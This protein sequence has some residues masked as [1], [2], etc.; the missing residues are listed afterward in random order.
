MT[1]ENILNECDK[2]EKSLLITHFSNN[3]ISSLVTM[4]HGKIQKKLPWYDT[5]FLCVISDA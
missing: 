5:L 4:E 1:G 2:L 3:H